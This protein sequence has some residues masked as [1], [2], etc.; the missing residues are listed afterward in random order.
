MSNIAP[1]SLCLILALGLSACDEKA[2]HADQLRER[3]GARDPGG[4]LVR[5][6]ELEYELLTGQHKPAHARPDR[7]A[8]LDLLSSF[9]GA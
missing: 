2:G 6:A 8:P 3:V 9:R 7:E 1:V 5:R 4:K